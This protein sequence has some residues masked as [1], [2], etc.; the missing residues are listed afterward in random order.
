MTYFVQN[1]KIKS[2]NVGSKI[3]KLWS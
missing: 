1:K 2:E 3:I